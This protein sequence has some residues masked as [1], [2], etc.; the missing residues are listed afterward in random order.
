MTILDRIDATLDGHCPCGG[1]PRPGSAYC[2]YDCEPDRATDRYS[3]LAAWYVAAR[4]ALASD[5]VVP[6]PPA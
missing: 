3:E 5:G 4:R 1:T 6:S 2:G